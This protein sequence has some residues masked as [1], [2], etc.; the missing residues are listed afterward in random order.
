MSGLIKPFSV[1]FS[2]DEID[3]F[4][5]RAKDI[6]TKGA[7][8]PGKNNLEL[9]DSFTKLVGAKYATAV[10]SGT[11]ALEIIY[12]SLKLQGAEVLV[13]A[14]TN[15]ATLES[16]IRAGARPVLYDSNLYSDLASI[17]NRC[18]NKTRAV[19]VVHIGGY[20]S[21]E[22]HEIKSFC[23]KNHIRLIED[24][25][26]AHGSK[27]RGVSA[28]LFGAANAFSMFATKIVTTSEGGLIVTNNKNVKN[29][30]DVFRDQ[31]KDRHGTKNIV[32]GSAWRMSELH[33]ALGAVQIKHLP[34]YLKR[35]NSIVK[36]Y[37]ENILQDKI[38]I[39]FNEDTYYSG[40]KFVALTA[41]PKQKKGLQN[42]LLKNDIKPGKGVYD[43]PLHLQPI[44]RT[45][46]H[47]KYPKAE[48]F[49]N[50]HV[51]LPIWK[52]LSDKE[53]DKV[54]DVVNKWSQRQ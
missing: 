12:R 6:L 10:S 18:S 36:S 21:P 1:S 46:F 4:I 49:A 14:N 43:I 8:I 23:H 32:F 25:S 20:I 47:V 41:N 40:Y 28:G 2:P 37:A 39:P 34:Q 13:P 19:V 17:T 51:C 33:A 48:K 29:I 54:I 53:V 42:F 27:F 31:G 16:V 24:A 35:N 3:D 22:I 30:C 15:Y 45:M 38:T 9:E 52:G 26:H 11:S 50:T 44:F 7:L 5:I